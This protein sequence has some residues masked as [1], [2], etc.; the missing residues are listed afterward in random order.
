MLDEISITIT[1]SIPLDVLILFDV[2]LDWGLDIARINR[3]ITIILIIFNIGLIL[4][5]IDLFNFNNDK[6]DCFNVA[7]VNLPNLY[8]NRIAAGTIIA[9]NRYSGS[10]K[11]KSLNITILLLC[12]YF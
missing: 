5:I 6:D 10:A 1:M 7:W 4:D 2:D 11:Y 8:Q 3:R 12:L 9:I